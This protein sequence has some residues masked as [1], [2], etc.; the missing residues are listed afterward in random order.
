M[1]SFNLPHYAPSPSEV[2][3]IVLNEN[4]FSIDSLE[5]S[6]LKWSTIFG[7]RNFSEALAA[8]AMCVR[9][10]AE[11]LLVSHFGEAIIKEVFCKY[12][13]ILAETISKESSSLMNVTISLTKRG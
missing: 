13:D 12:R 7:D 3:S 5:D 8:S 6:E 11:P 4:S 1:D 2:K 10:V 9:A